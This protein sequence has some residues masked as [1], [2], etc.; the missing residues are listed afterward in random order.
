MKKLMALAVLTS[1]GFLVVHAQSEDAASLVKSGQAAVRK[2]NYAE[3]DVL[4]ARAAALGDTREAAPA[5][6][7]LGVRALGTNNPLAAQGFFERVLKIDPR[8]PEAAPAL[9]WLANLRWDDPAAA[10]SLY[11]QALDVAKPG[12]VELRDTLRRYSMFL[13]RHGRAEDAAAIDERFQEAQRT[14][15]VAPRTDTLPAGVYRPGGG[16]RPPSLLLKSE[17]QYTHEARA[18]K[19]QGTVMLQIDISPDGVAENFEVVRSLEPG[20]DQKAIEAVRQWRF[21]P[22]AKD[23]APVTVRATIEVNFRL[24]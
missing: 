10:E 15:T 19:I 21:K 9:S 14:A 24:M 16:V 2:A 11:T 7:Y 1:A 6:L 4:Y 23:G 5:L 8:G 13:R 17:P 20:L 18:A 3:A 12:S 22:G